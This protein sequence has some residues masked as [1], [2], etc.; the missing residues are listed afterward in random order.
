MVE[1]IHEESVPRHNTHSICHA[2]GERNK[3]KEMR[4]LSSGIFYRSLL[5]IY[6]PRAS[7]AT[8]SESSQTL[9]VDLLEA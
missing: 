9:T 8:S 1:Y 4:A 5:A 6:V 3:V 7:V 2:Y